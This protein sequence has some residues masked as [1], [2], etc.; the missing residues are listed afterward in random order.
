MLKS[1]RV[2][3]LFTTSLLVLSSA[4][5]MCM[6]GNESK[7]VPVVVKSAPLSLY[8]HTFKDATDPCT[9]QKRAVTVQLPYPYQAVDPKSSC[10]FFEG[11]AFII[12]PS[13]SPFD[14][15]VTHPLLPCLF[16]RIFDPATGNSLVFHKYVR[17]DMGSL[18]VLLEQLAPPRPEDLSITLYTC[19][20]TPTA[21][22]PHMKWFG[23]RTQLQEMNAVRDFLAQHFSIP[24]GNIERR[25]FTAKQHMGMLLLGQYEGVGVT[26]G[27]RKNGDVFT[28]TLFH[29]DSFGIGHKLV[30][31][32]KKK[33]IKGNKKEV[34]F[35]PMREHV[36][37][38]MSTKNII[39]STVRGHFE[40]KA[41]EA[42]VWSVP[43]FDHP[44]LH[45]S[46]SSLGD[47]FMI[48]FKDFKLDSKNPFAAE[49]MDQTEA[50]NEASAIAE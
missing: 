49:L 24:N 33:L 19:E 28:T 16:G 4:K 27:V 25:F 48:E 31:K 40:P 14:A 47:L 18:K 12:D 37:F 30:P 17:H 20:M 22:Q 8:P 42:T 29:Q 34:S 45:V 43:F 35:L 26:I 46:M 44:G 9:S 21:F 6:E 13:T 11:Q 15:F 1:M 39:S 41:A 5:G 32:N 3:S 38:G 2:L 50:Q 36:Q 7:S 10:L 23:S